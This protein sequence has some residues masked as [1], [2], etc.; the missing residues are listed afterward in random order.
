MRF[1]A[2]LRPVV[3]KM[4]EKHDFLTGVQ[5]E[6]PKDDEAA[7]DF[8]RKFSVFWRVIGVKAAG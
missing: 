1:S 7:T 5:V 2:A 3:R 8:I 6:V 4:A